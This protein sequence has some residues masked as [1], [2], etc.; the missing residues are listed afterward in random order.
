MLSEGGVEPRRN[1][2]GQSVPS[3]EYVTKRYLGI[4]AHSMMIVLMHLK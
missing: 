1:M 2:A 4:G 3:Y